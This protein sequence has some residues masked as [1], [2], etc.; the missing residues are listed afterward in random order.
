[1]N[2][3]RKRGGNIMKIIFY[4]FIDYSSDKDTKKDID[5]EIDGV[6]SSKKRQIIKMLRKSKYKKIRMQLIINNPYLT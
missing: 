2:Y 5:T 4:N 3:L 6:E 1:M